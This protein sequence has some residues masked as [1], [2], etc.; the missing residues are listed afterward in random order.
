MGLSMQDIEFHE[1]IIEAAQHTRIL[2][3]WM[4]IRNIVITALLIA[5]EKRFAI[6]QHEI[7][8]LIEKHVE[9]VNRIKE[10]DPQAIS[11]SFVNPYF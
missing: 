3:M 4:G 1:A 11:I 6:E 2:H 9:I 8:Q 5:T 10:G 7:N